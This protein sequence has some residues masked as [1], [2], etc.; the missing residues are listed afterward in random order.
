MNYETVGKTTLRQLYR[1]G[2]IPVAA[3]PDTELLRIRATADSDFAKAGELGGYVSAGVSLVSSWVGPDAVLI[4]CGLDGAVV[5]NGLYYRVVAT[6]SRLSCSSAY[7]VSVN[8][9][10]IEGDGVLS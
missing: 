5:T 2:L 8:Q 3:N 6:D 7:M 4:D 9:S 1:P 10:V